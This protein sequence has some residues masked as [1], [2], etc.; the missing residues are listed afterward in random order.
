MCSGKLYWPN[1]LLK[2][3]ARAM[4]I[5][6]ESQL[7]LKTTGQG[8]SEAQVPATGG[9]SGILVAVARNETSTQPP[10]GPPTALGR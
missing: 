6:K 7:Q 2:T 5:Y 8:L 1:T 4:K 10:A 9:K 3:R